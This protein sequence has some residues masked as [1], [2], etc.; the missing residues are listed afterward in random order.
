MSETSAVPFCT[1]AGCSLGNT[2]LLLQREVTCSRDGESER[3]AF[4]LRR[5]ERCHMGFV[6]PVPADEILACFYTG[7][8][9]YYRAEG[10]QARHEATSWKYRVARLR[11]LHL[12][13]P[14]G[15]SRLLSLVGVLAELL[16]RKS[17]T[18]TLGVPLTL[19]QDARILD[20]G[21]GTGLWLL[22]MRLL[23]YSQLLGYDIAANAD[24]REDL[25]TAG[26][27][28]IPHEG[29]PRVETA[30]VDCVRLEQVFEHLANPLAVLRSIHRVLRPNGL[31][32]MTF[33]TIYP[34]LRMKD[35]TAVVDHL[36][37]PLHLAHHSVESSR[38][39]LR[40]AGFAQI[41]SRITARERFLTLMARKPDGRFS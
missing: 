28:V 30:S 34:W 12:T 26:V 18:F 19:P 31:L 35:L 10:Q 25:A 38:R 37:L 32:V 13:N 29:L 16:A 22:S 2:R 14:G 3:V 7:E 40:A 39:L 21:Y 24:R 4:E 36:Q 17:I 5:C 6:N 41:V 9:P 15:V 23:G 1:E 11:Y 20:Y 33:P 8:Y 27:Q